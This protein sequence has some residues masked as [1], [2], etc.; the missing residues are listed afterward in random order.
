MPTS[1]HEHPGLQ[2]QLPHHGEALGWRGRSYVRRRLV[3]EGY[4]T[5]GVLRSIYHTDR[6]EYTA[7]GAERVRSLLDDQAEAFTPASFAVLNGMPRA[8]PIT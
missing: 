4:A 8:V 1:V 7:C 5:N 3:G 2:R 6:L